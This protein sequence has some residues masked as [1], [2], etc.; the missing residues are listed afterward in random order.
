MYNHDNVTC[1]ILLSLSFHLIFKQVIS[2]MNKWHTDNGNSM[3]KV[4]GVCGNSEV[5]DCTFYFRP[6]S[7]VMAVALWNF[8]ICRIHETH[9]SAYQMSINFLH[10]NFIM[11]LQAFPIAFPIPFPTCSDHLRWGNAHSYKSEVP[12]VLLNFYHCWIIVGHNTAA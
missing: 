4:N 11:Q 9:N 5:E 7:V 8:A 3:L 10:C 1:N 6:L 2:T 12:C